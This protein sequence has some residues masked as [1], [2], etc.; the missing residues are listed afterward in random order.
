MDLYEKMP[1][2]Y[3]IYKTFCGDNIELQ[4]FFSPD[5]VML[6]ASKVLRYI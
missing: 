3:N 5:I 6:Q 4:Y 1:E 2:A